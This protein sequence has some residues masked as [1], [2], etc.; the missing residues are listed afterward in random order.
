MSINTRM[1]MFLLGRQRRGMVISPLKNMRLANKSTSGEKAII[2]SKDT[3][4]KVPL[5]QRNLFVFKN[6]NNVLY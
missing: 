6:Q 1:G 4:K 2:G 3:K 5:F